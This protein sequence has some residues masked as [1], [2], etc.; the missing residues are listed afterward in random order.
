MDPLLFLASIAILMLTA[1]LGIAISRKTKFPLPLLLFFAGI[2]LGKVVYYDRPLVQLPGPFLS[3][4]SIL[5]VMVLVFDSMSR[6]K[7]TH[8]DVIS[9]DVLRFFIVQAVLLLVVFSSLMHYVFGYQWF[10]SV[11]FSV[12]VLCT[13]FSV[14]YARHAL[15]NSRTVQFVRDES[16]L[17]SALVA[18]LPFLI[19][20]FT[21]LVS[22]PLRGNVVLKLL[23]FITSVFSGIGI[24]IL[25][26]LT[27]YNLL[28]ISSVQKY[29]GLS[30]T[31][32]VVIAY[33]LAQKIGGNGFVSVATMGVI[34]AHVFFKQKH[35]I[36]MDVTKLDSVVELFLF[37]IAGLVVGLPLSLSFFKISL[38]LFV[39]YVALRLISV[40]ASLRSYS[41]SEKL[42]L[43]LFVP[44]GP[45][46]VAVAFALLN[47]EFLGVVSIVQY[48]MAFFV[49][50]LLLD[51]IL[52]RIG[53]Y[54]NR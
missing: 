2:L 11:L 51:V 23:P 46:T 22:F 32:F 35:L 39:V 28:H 13:E 54:R 50:S 33:L 42:E 9:K 38:G 1:L 17:S 18:L 4:L 53:I 25:L 47:Y 48:L 34:F 3:V 41:F 30:L 14:L 12:L 26:S 20:S 10:S 6:I 37:T 16:L 24:G 21:M 43:G 19:L 7:F 29:A 31:S 36:K 8:I 27:L 52:T 5:I 40:A 44:K 45:I 15:P 49:Y